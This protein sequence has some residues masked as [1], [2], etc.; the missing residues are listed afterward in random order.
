MKKNLLA[1][2]FMAV[3]LVNC[4]DKEKAV[5]PEKPE[6]KKEDDGYLKISL[7]NGDTSSKS[8]NITKSSAD[9][10]RFSERPSCQT[11]NVRNIDNRWIFKSGG[12][13]EYDNGKI[14]EDKTCES[15][16]CSDFAKLKG[17]WAI[18]HVKSNVPAGKFEIGDSLLININKRKRDNEAEFVTIK[19]FV[20]KGKITVFSDKKIVLEK[21]NPEDKKSYTDEY[22]PVN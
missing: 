9:D 4:S 7:I 16:C 10:S 8:W 5:D 6:V 18:K 1:W 22:T 21:N 17:K 11:S 2:A 19:E 13:F 20:I 3:L 12:F 14:T 15:N